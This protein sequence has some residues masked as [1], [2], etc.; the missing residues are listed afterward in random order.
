MEHFFGVLGGMETAATDTYLARLR[1]LS[2]HDA[3]NYVLLN[4]AVP[5]TQSPIQTAH[6]LRLNESFH[7]LL[8]LAPDFLVIPSHFAY[9]WLDDLQRQTTI[10]ILNMPRD[11]IAAINQLTPGAQRIGLLGPQDVAL[12]SIYDQE[13]LTAGY[14][15][16]HPSAEIIEET[17]TLLVQD[18]RARHFVDRTLFHKLITDMLR[19]GADAVILGCSELSLANLREPAPHLPVIDPQAVLVAHTLADALG[20]ANFATS[21]R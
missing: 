8:A 14:Q 6:Y 18:I 7:Q 19:L 16:V 9:F 4:D 5:V 13:L 17:T 1:R 20:T 15:P 21:S 10:P 3:L 2:T 12:Q 11:S